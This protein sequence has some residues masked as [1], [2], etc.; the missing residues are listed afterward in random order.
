MHD[1]KITDLKTLFE[2]FI[3]LNNIKAIEEISL[4]D[5]FKPDSRLI[6]SP[7]NQC[8]SHCLHCASD[9]TP[10]GEVMPFDSFIEIDERFFEPFSVVDFG[11]RGDPISY[12][13]N[14]HNLADLIEHLYLNGI[15]NFTMAS[16]I[17]SECLPVYN[18]LETLS[19]GNLIIDSAVTYHHYFPQFDPFKLHIMLNECLKNFFTFSREIHVSLL[20]DLY[21]QYNTTMANEV[22]DTFFSNWETIFSEIKMRRIDDGTFKAKYGNKT[23]KIVIKHMNEKVHPLGRFKKYL[24]E[25]GI[26]EEYNKNYNFLDNYHACPDLIKWPGIVLEPDGSLNLCGSFESLECDN[27]II[28][29]IFSKP[30]PQVEED[31]LKFHQKEVL[32]FSSSYLDLI[33]GKKSACKLTENY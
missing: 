12:Q 26:F 14:G 31:L 6:I 21:P 30:F 32:W 25:K 33:A 11:R 3:R 8:H 18:A 19:S 9:S 27:A 20:G 10:Q 13:S 1:L 29:N 22:E 7:S 2:A 23:R 4:K 16:S 24:T 5:I 28:S 17:H 15:R